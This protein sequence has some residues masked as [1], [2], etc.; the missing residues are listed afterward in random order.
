[1]IKKHKLI[2][3]YM[4]DLYRGCDILELVGRGKKSSVVTESRR[5]VL[6]FSIIIIIKFYTFLIVSISLCSMANLLAEAIAVKV[7]CVDRL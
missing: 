1:M 4:T 6:S 7:K 3:N 5:L 2:R